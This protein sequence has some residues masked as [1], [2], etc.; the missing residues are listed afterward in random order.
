MPDLITFT[1]SRPVTHIDRTFTELTLREPTGLDLT[2]AGDPTNMQ[3]YTMRLAAQLAGCGVEVLHAMRARD[4][5]AI[6]KIVAGF[7][8]DAP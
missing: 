6:G 5:I 7:L 8:A 4:V 3:E 1:L 2:A